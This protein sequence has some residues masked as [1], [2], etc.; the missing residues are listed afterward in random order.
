MGAN[1]HLV[2]VVRLVVP[3]VVLEIDVQHTMSR[4]TRVPVSSIV[5]HF[6]ILH[7]WSLNLSLT[8]KLLS[9]EFQYLKW[10]VGCAVE[11]GTLLHGAHKHERFVSGPE[12]I[13]P[14]ECSK[15]SRNW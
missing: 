3:V 4:P 9:L 10:I 7:S 13:V 1:Q 12:L 5:N 6:S 11:R 15:A 14:I 8:V 2:W